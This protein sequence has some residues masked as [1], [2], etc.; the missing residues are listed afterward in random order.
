LKDTTINHKFAKFSEAL[1]LTEIQARKENEERNKIKES[2]N[3]SMAMR[4]EE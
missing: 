4:N 3:I 1:Y 2:H